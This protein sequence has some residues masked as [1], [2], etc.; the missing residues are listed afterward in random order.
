MSRQAILSMPLSFAIVLVAAMAL[1]GTARQADL[2]FPAE[3]PGT[4]FTVAESNSDAPTAAPVEVEQP[5]ANPTAALLPVEEQGHGQE[6]G[7]LP[8]E[9]PHTP[10]ET[11]AHPAGPS[12]PEPPPALTTP[13]SS[14]TRDREHWRPI[15]SRS[16]PPSP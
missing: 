11:S 9:A 8:D 3:N 13:E 2:G 7:K 12:A 4:S 14:T 5:I 1:S 6:K 16:S 15:V 10:G